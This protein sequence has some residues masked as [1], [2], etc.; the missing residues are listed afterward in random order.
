MPA[1]A[2]GLM[3]EGSAERIGSRRSWRRMARREAAML[4]LAALVL[5]LVTATALAA[6]GALTQPAGTAGCVSQSGSEHCADGHGLNG[7]YDVAASLDG[8]SV[9]AASFNAN[10]VVRLN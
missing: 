7:V 10:A 2:G 6:T 4:W 5:L 8:K 1:D 3:S 9:Y